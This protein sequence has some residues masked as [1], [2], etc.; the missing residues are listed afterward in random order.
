[1][2][3][4][5][6]FLTFGAVVKIRKSYRDDLYKFCKLILELGFFKDYI[7]YFLA[8]ES[9]VE[10]YK[11][12]KTKMNRGELIELLKTMS[13]EQILDLLDESFCDTMFWHYIDINEGR[14]NQ[15][16][17]EHQFGKGF[18]FGKE[19][20]YIKYD[21]TIKVLSVDDLIFACNMEDKF[22]L[23]FVETSF[24]KELDKEEDNDLALYLTDF[25]E[26]YEWE[27]VKYSNGLY[28]ILDRQTEEL[29]GFFNEESGTLRD[30]IERTF[31]RMV[32]FFTE[33]EEHEEIE[34]VEK[35]VNKYVE[36]ARKYHLYSEEQ[37][38]WLLKWLEEEKD[39]L[40][41]GEQ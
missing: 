2:N 40:E 22:N 41:E 39:Y 4:F 11:E 12:D 14:Q 23:G 5:E 35:T 38:K 34:Y 16:C 1:M 18:T 20:D 13:K 32:D 3:D 37:I 10:K 6:L 8:S 15:I 19:E 9:I 7:I 24:L 33:E 36:L 30:C 29:V 31:N 26:W 25:C 27:L 17:L 21:D 28:N